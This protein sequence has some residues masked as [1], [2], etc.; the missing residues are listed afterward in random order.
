MGASVLAI[1]G[2]SNVLRPD[3]SAK[4]Y[5]PSGHTATAFMGAELLR[6][7]YWDVSP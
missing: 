5:F 6:K 3:G 4:N 1:R 7:E 2:S